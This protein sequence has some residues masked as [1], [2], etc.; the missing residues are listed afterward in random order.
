VM[1]PPMLEIKA[2]ECMLAGTVSFGPT[3]VDKSHAGV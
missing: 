1:P 3:S 2:F